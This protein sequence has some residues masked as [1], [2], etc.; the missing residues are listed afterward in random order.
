M[1]THC[2]TLRKIN[3]LLPDDLY[4]QFRTRCEFSGVSMAA[5][6]RTIIERELSDPDVT[7]NEKVTPEDRK[8]ATMLR[9]EAAVKRD[10]DIVRRVKDGELMGAV[11][12]LY[13]LSK[14]GVS[15]IVARAG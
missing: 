5:V 12:S 9:R 10:A 1:Y 15:R 8:L 11:A 3:I 14:S 13:G 2:M 7:A 6:V 4:D